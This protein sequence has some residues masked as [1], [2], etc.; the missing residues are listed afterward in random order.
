[1]KSLTQRIPLLDPLLKG[2]GQI[3]LQENAWTGLLFLAGIF[4]GSVQMGVGALLAT[5][6][7]TVTAKLLKYKEEEIASGLYGFSAALVGVAL[8]FY[9]QSVA[10]IWIAIVIGA[11]LATIIQHFFIVKK[12]PVFTFPFVFITWILLYVFHQVYPVAPSDVLMMETHLNQDF[13]HALRGFGQVIFQGSTFA[14]L[15]FFIAVFISSPISALYAMAAAVFA[16]M[17]SKCLSLNPEESIALGLGSYNAVLCAIVF[18]GTKVMD[19]FWVLLSVALALFIAWLMGKYDFTLL[20]FPFV[21]GTCLTLVIK[22]IHTNFFKIETTA[23][24]G[25]N[26]RH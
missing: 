23:K 6:S 7:G 15:L 24:T 16:A 20:T 1:M 19:G 2:I 21:A 11:I 5:L 22:N 4:C 18:A 13:A 9:F 12:I 14:G 25:A 10:I 3:M 8:P 26:Q 17:I